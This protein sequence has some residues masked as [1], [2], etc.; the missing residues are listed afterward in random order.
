MGS[1]DPGL[2]GCIRTT[3][4]Y[5]GYREPWAASSKRFL[6][7]DKGLIKQVLL[8]AWLLRVGG[9]CRVQRCGGAGLQGAGIQGCRIKG[10]RD[11]GMQE[12]GD[13]GVQGYRMRGCGM[14]G[15][16][17]AGMQGYR[18]QGCREARNPH[19]IALVP[20]CSKISSM[21]TCILTVPT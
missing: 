15:W 2:L 21:G 10:C 5:C 7:E 4:N 3:Q 12:C 1:L 13:A 14:Q 20:L 18:M 6:D 16:R 8:S 17:G 19:G 9:W 11:A